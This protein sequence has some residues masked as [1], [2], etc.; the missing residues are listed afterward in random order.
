MSTIDDLS[1]IY[2]RRYHRTSC[3]GIAWKT[4][5]QPAQ[6]VLFSAVLPRCQQSAQI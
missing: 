6:R 3:A 5:K 1:E 2:S 4:Q